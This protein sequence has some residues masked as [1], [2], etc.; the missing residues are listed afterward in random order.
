LIKKFKL[1]NKQA[2]AIL[3]MRLSA[4]SGLERKKIESDYKTTLELIKKLEKILA[5]DKEILNVIKAEL[6]DLKEKY[7]DSRRTQVVRRP[8]GELAAAD[9][10]PDEQV[11]V[12]LTKGNYIK[13]MPIGSYRSQRRGG[14]GV[15]GITTKEEDTV[16][17]ILQASTHDDLLYFT[18][19]GRVFTSKVYELVSTTRQAKGQ[20]IVNLLQISPEKEQVTSIVNVSSR[21]KMKYLLMATKRGLVKKTVISAYQQ[22]RRSGLIAIRLRKDDELLWVRPTSGEDQV[23]IAT[24]RGMAIRFPEKDIRPM[25]RA[26]SG[27]RGIRL[28]ANDEVIGMEIAAKRSQIEGAGDQSEVAEYGRKSLGGEVMIITEKAKGKKTPLKNYHIQ[29][30]GGIGLRTA[31]LNERTGDISQMRL[32]EGTKA[33]VVLISR[34]GQVIRMPITAVKRLGRPTSGVRLMRL[35]QGDKIASVTVL[36]KMKEDQKNNNGKVDKSKI[37]RRLKK[38]RSKKKQGGR[39]MQKSDS[40]SNH[41]PKKLKGSRKD[42][43]YRY[44]IKVEKANKVEKKQKAKEEKDSDNY[45]GNQGIWKRKSI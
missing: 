8:V 5:S 24:K 29:R 22:V 1:S 15:L 41:Q 21:E 31:R 26:A 20:A 43:M 35:N 33:D 17:I 6:S 13:R 19:K 16:N 45:W 2:E 10:I 34:K 4:L 42:Q 36:E 3:E 18:N 11:I 28:R 23:I 14:K 32:V 9:L 44:G 40:R 7:P 37:D 30:R 39:K 27:V 12:T 25:G 38:Y